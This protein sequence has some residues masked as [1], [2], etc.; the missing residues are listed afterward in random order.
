MTMPP[1]IEFDVTGTAL[2]ALVVIPMLKDRFPDL[3]DNYGF[4]ARSGDRVAAIDCA[5]DAPY[6]EAAEAMGWTI[7]DIL[8]TH[9]HPDHVDGVDALRAATGAKAW[10]ARADAH[11]LPALDHVLDPGDEVAL[12]GARFAVW[13]VSGHTNGHIAYIGKGVA[14]TGDSLMAGG[15]GRLFEGTPEQMHASLS[16]FADLPGETLIA[17]GHEYTRSNLAFARTLEPDSAELISR[18]EAMEALLAA[19]QPTVPSRL[20][21]ERNTN[22]FL[23]CHLPDLKSATGT[24]GQSDSE[25]FAAIR[26]AK[27]AF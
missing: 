18:Q 6:R 14:F 4:L 12:G 17:S 23:R 21:L 5:R 25:T 15:C 1:Q 26:A 20:D 13:D 24:E 10:G 16:Q 22:P 19:G 2:D 3:L 8:L 7:T 27:D 11:R 9:H